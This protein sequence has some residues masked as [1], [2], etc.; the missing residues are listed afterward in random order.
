MKD[1]TIHY[2]C[3]FKGFKINIDENLYDILG[4]PEHTIVVHIIPDKKIHGPNSRFYILPPGMK[5]E[6]I[7]EC[8]R[9]DCNNWK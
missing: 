4:E 5:L 6:E 1:N 3:N 8:C 7:L 9:D 2:S